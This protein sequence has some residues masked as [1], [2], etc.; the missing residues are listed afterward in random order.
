MME[1]SKILPHVELEEARTSGFT[2]VRTEGELRHDASNCACLIYFQN[3]LQHIGGTS[4][5]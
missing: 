1:H 5:F 3:E 4:Y 2:T